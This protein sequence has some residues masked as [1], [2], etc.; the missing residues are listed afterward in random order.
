MKYWEKD[1][2]AGY[3]MKLEEHKYVILTQG[4]T[5]PTPAKMAAG[6]LRYHPERV[7]ALLDNETAGRDTGEIMGVGRGIP[8]V[9][10]LKE[11]IGMGA[12][13]L[14]TGITPPGGQL[15][16]EWRRLILEAIA[17][18]LDVVSGLHTFLKED[19]EFSGAARAHRV[20]LFD[21]R[22]PPDELTVNG[23][24]AKSLANLRVHT[25]GTDCNC[26]KKVTAL[27]ID[28]ALR[29]QGERSTFI[30]TGQTGILI[31]G[32]GIAL[33]RVISDFVAGAAE[34][35]VL[36]NADY[37]YLIIEGQGSLVHPLYSGVT[38]GMLHGFMPQALILCH[39]L[40]RRIMRGSADTPVPTL[41]TMID[42]YERITLPVYPAKV[43]GIAI[44]SM[45]VDE[46][47]ARREIEETEKR[48]NLPAT[49]V[50]RLGADKLA[51]AVLDF[52]HER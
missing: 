20:S 12:N 36:E 15:P 45:E 30:A 42:L 13:A 23:C 21:L 33:D 39:Q 52:R 5:H 18:G 8:I 29:Q 22:R 28:Q 37:D 49:D 24:R 40:G 16:I 44:N 11:A 2:A 10:T 19:E 1:F 17:A 32:R 14:L 38:L 27:E 41:E 43:I 48:L 47:T 6:I 3:S 46:S 4:R 34:R 50:V 26:G 35:L 51:R 25:V 31:S 9:G 7:A